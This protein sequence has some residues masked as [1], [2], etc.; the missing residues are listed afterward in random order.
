MEENKYSIIAKNISKGYKMYSSPKQKLMDLILPKGAGKTFY[1]LKDLSFKVEKG[2]VVGLLGL[3]GSGKSTLS[4]ILG[5]VSMPTSGEIKINGESALI[6]IGLGMNNFLT[7]IENIELKAL[8]MGYK[9][10]EVEE[11]KQEIIDFADIGEFIN[12]PLRTYSSGMRSRLG[13]AIS[14]YTNPDILVIDEALSVGDPTF[15]QKCL[16]KMNEFKESGKTIFFVSHSLPQIKQFC[17]KAMWLEYGRLREYGDVEEVLP[18]YQ[19]YINDINKMSE[20]EKAEYKRKVL[21]EQEHSLLQEFKLVDNNLKKFKPKGKII[22]SV[23]LIN[24][25][26][27]VKEVLFNFDLTTLAFGF[28]P[29]IIRKRYET[30][31][32]ILLAQLLNLFVVA[33]PISVITNFVVTA[34]AAIFTGKSYVNYLI[35]EKSF[36]PYDIW[37]SMNIGESKKGIKDKFIKQRKKKLLSSY[38]SILFITISLIFS[39]GYAFKDNIALALSKNDV[40]MKIKDYLIIMTTNKDETEIIDSILVLNSK[41]TNELVG[42]VYP[43]KIQVLFNNKSDELNKIASIQDI[44][45]LKSILKSNFN[46]D[47]SGYIVLNK[48]LI[49]LSEDNVEMYSKLINDVLKIDSHEFKEK[50]KVLLENCSEINEESLDLFYEVFNGGKLFV[51]NLK[52]DEVLLGDIIEE[53]ILKKLN[54]LDKANYKILTTDKRNLVNNVLIK[55]INKKYEEV[56]NNEVLIQETEEVEIENWEDDI[57]EDEYTA[58]STNQS[59]SNS[60]NSNSNSNSDSNSNN[61]GNSNNTTP[62][63]T[64]PPVNTTPSP[65][66]PA[67]DTTPKPEAPPVEEV[68]PVEE[69]PPIEEA[70]PVEEAPPIE[71][72]PPV[73][74]IPPADEISSTEEFL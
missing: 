49:N 29:S 70:P 5:G 40:Q 12:Q 20:K 57:Y 36:L 7:G 1:A 74:Q 42:T 14:V 38:I 13:F 39:M 66:P 60:S 4:N 23:K 43:G 21:K 37:S 30:G 55:D 33:F 64:T 71:E 19:A 48:S 34:I 47:S 69:I 10:S 27:I 52:Y 53:E 9:K 61:N 58:P 25:D 3:N 46:I 50:K 35:E 54:L 45:A 16:D 24:N 8:M 28:I 31:V 68:P 6:A 65:T 56:L 41:A 22:K 51:S 18:R 11:I 72:V 63:V 73:E 32:L 26:K 44:E 2:E 59:N 17:N 67:V 62:P 15:T